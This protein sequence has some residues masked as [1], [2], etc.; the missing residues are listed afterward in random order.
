MH[1]REVD[2][3]GM[4]V[5]PAFG[6]FQVVLLVIVMLPP[7]NAR[8]ASQ[9]ISPAAAPDLFRPLADAGEK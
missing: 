2:E 5:E 7:V 6:T 4:P 1:T 8:V 3:A 9:A